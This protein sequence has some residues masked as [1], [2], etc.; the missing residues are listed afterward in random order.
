MFLREPPQIHSTM[1]P[2][3]CPEMRPA[4]LS[5]LALLSQRLEPKNAVVSVYI[6]KSPSSEIRHHYV[7]ERNESG[8]FISCRRY[9]N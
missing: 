6:V 7:C 1:Y 5:G 4:K 8:A 3:N 9:G 2:Q